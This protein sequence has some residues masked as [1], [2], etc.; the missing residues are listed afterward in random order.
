MLSNTSGSVD[1]SLR[2]GIWTTSFTQQLYCDLVRTLV[3]LPTYNEAA[4]IE[5]VLRRTRAAMPETEILVVDD[6]SP[7][8]TADVAEKASGEVGAVHVLRREGR[9]GLGDAYKAGFAWG[10]E[11]DFSVLVEMD[12]DLSHDPAA[13]PTLIAALADHD[14]TIGSR[15]IPG[16]SVPR[17]RP[18]RRLLSWGGNRYAARVLGVRVRDMTSGFRAYRAE[19]LEAI[20]LGAVR[21]EGYGFQIEMTYRA[22]QLGARIR[23]VPIRFVDREQGTSKMSPAIV[24]EAL[25]LVTWWALVRSWARLHRVLVGAGSVS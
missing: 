13:L 5:E 8:G 2:H 6:G 25:L 23:E 21:A 24:V 19:L 3:V 18:H 12:S 10:L 11:Q 16:G 15:Y 22:A 7:D 9:R 20:D 1:S 17:W 4:T 14:L